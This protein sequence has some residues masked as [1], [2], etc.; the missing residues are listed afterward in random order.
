MNNVVALNSKITLLENVLLNTPG[1]FTEMTQ[2]TNHFFAPGV[3]MRTLFIPAGNVAVGKVHKHETLNILLKGK[4][5]VVTD[6]GEEII[7]EAP[8]IFKSHPGRKAVYTVTD[9]WLASVFPNV[10]NTE[11]LKQLEADNILEKP[12]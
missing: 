12:L 3:Y 6:S 4:L 2:F 7:A 5:A 11:D 10:S 9:V 8:Y 1:V